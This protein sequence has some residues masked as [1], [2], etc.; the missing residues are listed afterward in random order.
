MLFF[1]VVCISSGSK[2]KVDDMAALLEQPLPQVAKS[3]CCDNVA[4]E[5]KITAEGVEEVA[6]SNIPAG[7][8]LK[9]NIVAMAIEN[10]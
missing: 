1:R 5:Y 8:S 7:I 9:R 2:L 10:D 3:P 4:C 6:G